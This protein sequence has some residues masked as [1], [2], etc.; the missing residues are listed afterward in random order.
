MSTNIK[1]NP[2]LF[3]LRQAAIKIKWI[4]SVLTLGFAKEGHKRLKKKKRGGVNNRIFYKGK[5]KVL[6]YF[7]STC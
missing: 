2:S 6:Q 5:S 7:G 4:S 1:K 3:V